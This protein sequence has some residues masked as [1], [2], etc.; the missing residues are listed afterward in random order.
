[1]VYG[2][3]LKFEMREA[4]IKPPQLR[5]GD[6]IGIVA[7]ASNIKRELLEAGIAELHRLGFKTKYFDSIFTKRLYF[8]GTD[9]RRAEEL[10][11]MFADPDVTAIF[12]ARGGYGAARLIPLLDESVI[13]AHPKIFMGYSDITT[14]LLY[15]QR[16]H[17][18]VVFHG[19]MVTRE[20]ADGEIQYDR[21]LLLR[22]LCQ[23]QAAGEVDLSGAQVLH[24]GVAHG[25]LVGG[26]LPMLT[27]S[28]GT[29]Y[30][31]D[32]REAILFI[33]DY[34]SKPYQVDRML[35]QLR[36]AGKLTSARGLVFGEMTECVQHP[37]QGYTIID[38]IQECVSDLVVPVLFGVRS[39]HS[40]VRN[41][42]L[43]LGVEVTMD[44][45]KSSAAVLTIEEPAV[46]AVG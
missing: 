2:P 36:A 40:D 17:H 25:R 35:T 23:A 42:V 3:F 41:Q 44:C 39:G 19:P 12:A 11:A 5:L 8:A 21:E 38:V 10:N 33:E 43:P 9:Q 32:A 34:A 28:I 24:P 31:L 18:W 13:G 1:V 20:F 30:E 6:T 37:E 14:L 26:C 45:S 15:L 7:P 16:Q 29:S 46:S 27:S 22:V 4:P